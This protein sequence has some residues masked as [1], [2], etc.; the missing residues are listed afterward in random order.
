MSWNNVFVS[1]APYGDMKFNGEKEVKLISYPGSKLAS[2]EDGLVYE[3]LKP[4]CEKSIHIKHN[5]NKGVVSS[6]FCGVDHKYV[7]NGDKVK[8]NST[9]GKYGDDKVF[10]YIINDEGKKVNIEKYFTEPVPSKVQTNDKELE[11]KKE[12]LRKKIEDDEYNE[13][14]KKDNEDGMENIF[15]NM[16]LLPFSAVN[17]ATQ[18]AKY[19][20]NKKKAEQDKK[21]KEEKIKKETEKLEKKNQKDKNIQEN[22]NRIKNLLK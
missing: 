19:E 7:T 3:P 4:F 8:K 10:F 1:P 6:V 16:M 13:K 21:D 5:T 14:R 9:I 18:R 2:P 15:V 11:K 22:I 12:E 17:S 20:Y